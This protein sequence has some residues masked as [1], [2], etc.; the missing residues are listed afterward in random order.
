LTHNVQATG[1]RFYD[2]AGTLLKPA[3]QNAQDYV[4]NTIGLGLQPNFLTASGVLNLNTFSA[5]NFMRHQHVNDLGGQFGVT[6]TWLCFDASGQP[7]AIEDFTVNTRTQENQITDVTIEGT[8]KGLEVRDNNNHNLITTRLQNA[9]SYWQNITTYLFGRCQNL[10]GFD[11]NP[12]PLELTS[13]QNYFQGIITYQQHY[14]NRPNSTIPGS[15]S[16]VITIGYDN[17]NDVF[18]NLPIVGAP[19]GPVL[20]GIGTVT[21]RKLTLQIE[22]VLPA[23]T[24]SHTCSKPNTDALVLTYKPI[25]SGEIFVDRDVENLTPNQGRYSRNT[26][27]TYKI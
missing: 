16:E 9:N 17:P 8:I 11:L 19:L 21:A 1:K 27:W 6:E 7:P 14:N 26:S 15:I 4:L 3:W 23:S 10:S 5:Y 22:A 24:Q 25:A 20:Q 2:S 12:Q 18:A 13:A